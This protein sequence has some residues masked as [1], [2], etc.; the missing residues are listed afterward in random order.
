MMQM[1]HVMVQMQHLSMM[2][3][4]HV[5][6]RDANVSLRGGDAKCLVVQ[7][8]SNEH[9]MM[10]NASCRCIMMQMS[11][12]RHAMMQMPLVGVP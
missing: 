2:V 11:F 3:L 12:Y 8:P 4:A 5:F 6:T 7:M 9:V 10:Q 1:S